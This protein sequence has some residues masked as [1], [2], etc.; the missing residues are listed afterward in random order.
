MRNPTQAPA[1]MQ[2][3]LPL[4]TIWETERFYNGIPL[5]I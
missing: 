1:K 4:P 5:A 2:K 3:T